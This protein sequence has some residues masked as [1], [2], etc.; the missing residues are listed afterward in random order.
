[1]VIIIII[2]LF[3]FGKKTIKSF[4]KKKIVGISF[5][6]MPSVGDVL[7]IFFSKKGSFYYFEG[8]CFSIKRKSFLVPDSSL[9]VVNKIKG[10]VINFFFSYFYNL[11]FSLK[12]SDFKRKK[13]IGKG[14][15]IYF[16]LNK[17]KFNLKF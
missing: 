16:I 14:S 6:Y 2:L 10:S 12:F 8:L 5:L 13:K 11:I 1:L 17:S 9:S 4:H 7:K 15:K 3:Y